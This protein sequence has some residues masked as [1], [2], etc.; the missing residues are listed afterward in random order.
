M[1][2]RVPK[3]HIVFKIQ[4]TSGRDINPY[5]FYPEEGEILLLP[6]HRFTVSSKPRVEQEYT[7]IDLVQTSDQEVLVS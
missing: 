6:S 2:S 5:S 3:T 7:I 1:A 4:V